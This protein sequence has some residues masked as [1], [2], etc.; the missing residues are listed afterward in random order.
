MIR[1]LQY[2]LSR[3]IQ[4]LDDLTCVNSISR[5]LRCTPCEALPTEETSRTLTIGRSGFQ[6]VLLQP[7]AEILQS[8]RTCY[9]FCALRPVYASYLTQPQCTVSFCANTYL[10]GFLKLHRTVSESLSHHTFS[11]SKLDEGVSGIVGGLLAALCCNDCTDVEEHPQ[12]VCRRLQ[13]FQ[14]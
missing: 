13:R 10:K 14:S 7:A 3:R 6:K 2:F 11:N 12:I 5:F 1:A 4:E 8:H 9:R